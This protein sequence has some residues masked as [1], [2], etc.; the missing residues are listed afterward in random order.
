MNHSQQNER[1]INSLHMQCF[2]L[3]MLIKNYF[4]AS[5]FYFLFYQLGIYMEMTKNTYLKR[6]WRFKLDKSIVSISI[7]STFTKPIRA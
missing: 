1:V 5:Y 7:T 2:S 6:N 4:N 3:C